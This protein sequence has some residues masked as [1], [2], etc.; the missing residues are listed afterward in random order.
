[1]KKE[2]KKNQINLGGNDLNLIARAGYIP[3]SSVTKADVTTN[4]NKMTTMRSELTQ[5][6]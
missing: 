5:A 6:W 3:N 1:M 2:L 4:K